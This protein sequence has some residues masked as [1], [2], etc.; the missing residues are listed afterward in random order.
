MTPN[1]D[2]FQRCATV[3]QRL[4]QP[5]T[6]LA[7]IYDPGTFFSAFRFASLAE[8]GALLGDFHVNGHGGR[9]YDKSSV[10]RF[11]TG[12]RRPTPDTVTT[13]GLIADQI[14][15]ARSGGRVR[16]RLQVRASGRWKLI[17]QATCARCERAY[18]PAGW[19]QTQCLRCL[20]KG[21]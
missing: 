9:R 3:A 12:E 11:N 6:A 21:R 16:V 19:H 20:R 8:L 4:R 18:A 17:P 1:A 7:A 13:Y 14:I 2:K 15:R 10:L 5:L